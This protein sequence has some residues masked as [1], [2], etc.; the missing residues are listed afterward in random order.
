MVTG[1]GS[2]GLLLEILEE[3]G[4]SMAQLLPAQLV[5]LKSLDLNQEKHGWSKPFLWSH[6]DAIV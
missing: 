1:P 5:W 2:P 3:V 4:A 6:G